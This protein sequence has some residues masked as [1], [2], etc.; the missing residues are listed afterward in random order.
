M[1]RKLIFLVYL[2]KRGSDLQDCILASFDKRWL[3]Y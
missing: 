2:E 3:Q 1:F